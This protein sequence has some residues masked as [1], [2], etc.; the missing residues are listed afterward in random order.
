MILYETLAQPSILL[1]VVTAGFMS[2]FIFDIANAL[3]R[4]S[5]SNKIIRFV[6]DFT[7]TIVSAGV[8]FFVILKT[9]YGDWRL[10]QILFFTASLL[11]QRATIGKLLAKKLFMCYNK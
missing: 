3:W 1:W 9:A 2:G 7:A 10:W 6:L 11:L 8:L 5:K 4:A